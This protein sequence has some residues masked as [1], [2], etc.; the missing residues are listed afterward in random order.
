MI[1]MPVRC[2]LVFH[3]VKETEASTGLWC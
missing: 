1:A 3:P 2:F